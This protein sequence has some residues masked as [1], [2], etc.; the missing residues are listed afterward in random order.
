MGSMSSGGNGVCGCSKRQ[1]ATGIV[2]RH[3]F[4]SLNRSPTEA[5][6]GL[7]DGQHISVNLLQY[8]HGQGTDRYVV[9]L[10]LLSGSPI[11][12]LHDQGDRAP[13]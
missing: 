12:S 13:I 8:V 4:E 5:L 11:E 10:H 7:G 1:V 3:N 9:R 2:H 6:L